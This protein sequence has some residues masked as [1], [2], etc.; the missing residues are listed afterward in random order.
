MLP[1]PDRD[2]IAVSHERH[3]AADLILAADESQAGRDTSEK[4]IDEG[5][6][7]GSPE[8]ETVVAD[9]VSIVTTNNT[10]SDLFM[11]RHEH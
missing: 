8:S 2:S 7:V 9:K 1:D 11:F 6:M 3:R 4:V 10:L 5:D